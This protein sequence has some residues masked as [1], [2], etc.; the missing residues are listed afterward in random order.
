[1]LK[2]GKMAT[3]WRHFLWAY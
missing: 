1:M 2:Y 3:T